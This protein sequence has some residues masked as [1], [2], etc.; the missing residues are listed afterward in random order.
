MKLESPRPG[1]TM[2][3]PEGSAPRR[4]SYEELEASLEAFL[5]D[6]NG[7]TAALGLRLRLA[8]L[9]AGTFVRHASSGASAR[10]PPAAVPVEPHQPRHATV[11]GARGRARSRRLLHRRRVPGAG[12]CGAQPVL[13]T[14]AARDDDQFVCTRGTSTA[15][16]TT[17]RSCPR[18]RSW[19]GATRPT[20]PAGLT[21]GQILDVF[22]ARQLRALR[23]QPRVPRQYDL[24]P[25][26]ARHRRSAP[27]AARA[28]CRCR[29]RNLA[30]RRRRLK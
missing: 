24:R 26:L 5:R 16:S 7:A 1:R 17:G 19:C 23:H 12:D 10:L 11:P 9:E 15:G 25:A 20:T 18:S 22:A 30:P 3:N 6:W 13:A 29:R 28:T 2:M 27:G 4:L 21:E 8:D 14:L